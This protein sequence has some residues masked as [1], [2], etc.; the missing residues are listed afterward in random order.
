ML[1]TIFK[2]GLF[3]EKVALITGGG[4]G[5]GLRT[6]RE[7]AQLG[8][9]VI[10]AGR[11]LENLNKGVA[12]I[13]KEGGKAHT[14]VCN[15][16]EEESVRSCIEKSLELCGTIDFL[17][18][19]A[20][21]QFPSPSEMI[22][23]KGWNAVIETN[24]SGT[25]FITQEVFNKVFE[26]KGGTVVNVIANMWKGFPMMSH[27]GAARAGVDNLTKSLAV[28]WAKYGV[29]INAVAPGTIRSSG[30]ETYD[31]AFKQVIEEFGKKN[32]A[33][34]MGTEEEVA[35][36]IVFLLSPAAAYITGETLKADG[37]EWLYSHLIAPEEHGK[38]A[39]WKD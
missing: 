30:L 9:T 21:G 6:A 23:R 26:K 32:Y 39:E 1:N 16:R 36:A 24:L 15:I 22:P 33:G 4:T 8:A 20:G 19:N 3:N 12:I 28:E 5:I 25:F 14:V 34:R 27:T 35:A 29:R 11:K 13:E 38:M 31:P 7:L 18:N 10:L 17:V 37:G 2:Q